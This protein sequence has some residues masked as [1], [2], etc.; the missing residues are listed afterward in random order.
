MAT[1]TTSDG[2]ELAYDVRGA[3]PTV[4]L[5]HGI[6]QCR[7]LWDPLIGDLASDHT[8]VAIDMRGHGASGRADTYQGTAGTLEIV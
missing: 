7:Q 6:T 1:T 3:G 8:V 2:V 5:V 4:V